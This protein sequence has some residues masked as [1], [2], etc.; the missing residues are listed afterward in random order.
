MAVLCHFGI[1]IIVANDFFAMKLH[2]RFYINGLWPGTMLHTANSSPITILGRSLCASQKWAY[3]GGYGES[4]R[5]WLV[6][7]RYEKFDQIC[8][9]DDENGDI[10]REAQIVIAAYQ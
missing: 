6:S 8:F 2:H 5:A 4:L 3:F 9:I 7:L 10:H 1:R